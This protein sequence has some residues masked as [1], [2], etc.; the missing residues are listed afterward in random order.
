[1]Q[2]CTEPG[3]GVL[4]LSGR[5]PEHTR[6]RYPEAARVHRWY[7]STRWLRL[8]LQVLQDQPLCRHCG[9]RGRKTLTEDIDHIVKHDGNP[10]LF[11]DRTNLQGLC[12]ACHSRKT[13]SGQ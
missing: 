11:W 9:Q 3:C 10:Q 6:Y 12:K 7:S 8:R 1:M 5:C 13:G 4:V 2:F